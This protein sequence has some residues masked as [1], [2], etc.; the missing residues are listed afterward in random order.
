MSVP[1]A[2]AA[3]LVMAAA[4]G[5]LNFT[6]PTAALRPVRRDSTP[7][8]RVC[9]SAD[10]CTAEVRLT[11]LGTGGF[12]IR[13]GGEAVLTAP[14]FNHPGLFAVVTPFWPMHSDSA[15]VD[16]EL[17]RFLG[18]DLAQ[19]EG[20]HSILVGHGHYDHLLD[21]PLIARRYLPNATIYGS[22]TTKRT[23]M[24]D[25]WLRAHPGRIDSL[26]PADSTI[27][28]VWRVGRWIY[29]PSRR[30]RFMA[31]RSGHAP[32]WWRITLAPCYEKRD[33]TS[34][35]RTGWGWCRGEPLSYL[36]D[37]LDGTGRPTLRIF[38]QDAAAGP[39]DVML[40]P[41]TGD[42]R[43]S[44]DIA[45]VCAGQ[46]KKVQDYPT[47]LLAA[48]RPR[49]VILG[50]WEDFFHRPDAMPTP[51]RFTDTKELAARLGLIGP[52]RWITPVPGG[53]VRVEY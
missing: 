26:A 19:L 23:L 52:G 18:N 47:L 43:K 49:Y 38:Y 14:S 32:N 39:L 1:T 25:A 10:R 35:P 4:T 12:L 30:M 36:I 51:V 27:A 3:L 45:I 29:S 22:L 15:T 48:L 6:G 42:D 33:R 31:M 41:F 17:R 46:F 24:G 34:L 9:G 8:L 7:V 50:H 2:A 13:T 5:C 37:V 40:P 16:R 20:V 21:V 28:S 44:V 53:Q 11:Y